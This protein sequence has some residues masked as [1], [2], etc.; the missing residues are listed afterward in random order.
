MEY[1]F[2]DNRNKKGLMAHCKDCDKKYRRK[3]KIK[4]KINEYQ[5]KRYHK[6]EKHRR[7]IINSRMKARYGITLAQFDKMVETQGGVCAVCGLPETI[8]ARRLSIDHNHK[9]GK[10]RALLCDRCNV[11]LGRAGDDIDLLMRGVYY[12]WQ[13]QKDKD[14]KEIQG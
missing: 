3:P 7:G 5:K 12:L 13:W 6:S 2:G 10:V 11:F 9:T 1:F 8:V 14:I 4:Q